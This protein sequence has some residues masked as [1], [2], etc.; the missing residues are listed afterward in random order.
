MKIKIV[1]PNHCMVPAP[2]GQKRAPHAYVKT[3]NTTAAQKKSSNSTMVWIGGGVGGGGGG[4]YWGKGD[5]ADYAVYTI[6]EGA[7]GCLWG[8]KSVAL[9]GYG[10][11]SRG[12]VGGVG[13]EWGGVMDQGSLV[14]VLRMEQNTLPI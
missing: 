13:V 11:G 8:K 10:C 7:L 4:G 3:V 14:L 1:I 6:S 9:A 5:T 12:W 2:G